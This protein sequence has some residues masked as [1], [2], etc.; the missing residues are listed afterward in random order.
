M[1]EWLLGGVIF[2]LTFLV[3]FF[4]V[5]AYDLRKKF[6]RAGYLH[7]LAQEEVAQKRY[8]LAKVTGLTDLDAYRIYYKDQM[9]NIELHKNNPHVKFQV[10]ESK[11]TLSAQLDYLLTNNK[12][13]E[14]NSFLRR[15]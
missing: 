8:A 5:L 11:R 2:G 14:I 6:W 4:G 9:E 10:A 15:K 7:Y 1:N 3:T 13:E 12:S